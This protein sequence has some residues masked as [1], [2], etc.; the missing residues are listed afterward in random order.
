MSIL[1]PP[2]TTISQRFSINLA[3]SR[4]EREGITRITETIGIEIDLEGIT[5]EM[6]GRISLGEMI[7][8][9]PGK[10]GKIENQENRESQ[11]NKDSQE[12]T[13]NQENT[14]RKEENI[15]SQE[16]IKRKRNTLD[17]TTK[18]EGNSQ[19]EREES[20]TT[21]E[22]EI[23][24]TRENTTTTI[25]ETTETEETTKETSTVPEE[26]TETST[27]PTRAIDTMA[28]IKLKTVQDT[29]RSEEMTLEKDVLPL[30]GTKYPASLQEKMVLT[31][32]SRYFPYN[33][34][35]FRA[36]SRS[37]VQ[38]RPR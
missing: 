26:T 2:A 34:G 7:G 16:K 38:M 31:S 24:M 6:M 1:Q 5:T 27:G 21:T 19:E 20:T 8:G 30:P 4:G 28:S 36:K 18:K 17:V 29:K 12:R 10:I 25:E 3:I 13:D 9:N 11:K 23:T 35:H 14:K 32:P 15:E 33:S 22:G 37:Q